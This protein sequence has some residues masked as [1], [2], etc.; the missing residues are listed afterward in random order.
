[1]LI[2]AAIAMLVMLS[3]KKNLAKLFEILSSTLWMTLKNMHPGKGHVRAHLEQWMENAKY[4][5]S[6]RHLR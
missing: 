4:H 6:E 3:K 5:K 2:R 1:M